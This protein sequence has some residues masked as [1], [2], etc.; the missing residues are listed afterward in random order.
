MSLEALMERLD[1]LIFSLSRILS[2][3]F[4]KSNM[5]ETGHKDT[6]VLNHF[7]FFLHEILVCTSYVKGNI[8]HQKLGQSH[9]KLF[10]IVFVDVYFEDQY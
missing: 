8:I 4:R 7:R 1:F 6:I 9:I 2:G 5:T 10:E 3:S